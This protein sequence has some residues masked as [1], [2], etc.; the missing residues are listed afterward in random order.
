[1]RTHPGFMPGVFY[2]AG[3]ESLTYS[4]LQTHKLQASKHLFL[5]G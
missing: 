3:I 4:K 1:M 2:W 5:P